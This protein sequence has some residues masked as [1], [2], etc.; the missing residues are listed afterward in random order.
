VDSN[1]CTCKLPLRIRSEKGG[2]RGVTDGEE[3]RAAAMV[4]QPTPQAVAM[5]CE[6]KSG[7]L[8]LGVGRRRLLRG[9]M[10]A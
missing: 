9:P 5:A 7:A 3:A 1:R 6:G 8:E 10:G 2:A 4:R